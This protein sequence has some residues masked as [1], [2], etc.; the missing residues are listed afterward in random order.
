ME[1][2]CRMQ[3]FLYVTSCNKSLRTFIPHYSS[4]ILFFYYFSFNIIKPERSVLQ[5]QPHYYS[6]YFI[7]F[8]QPVKAIKQTGKEWTDRPI[9]FL[10]SCLIPNRLSSVCTARYISR[11]R[12]GICCILRSRCRKLFWRGILAGSILLLC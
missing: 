12:S 10:F 9:L 4:L 2:P 3:C 1:S 6:I 7:P 5:D 11:F 8:L